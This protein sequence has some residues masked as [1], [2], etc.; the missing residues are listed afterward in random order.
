MMQLSDDQSKAYDVLMQ[1][2]TSNT[3]QCC[4]LEGKPGT[5]KTFLLKQVMK[6]YKKP[7]IFTAPTNKATKVLY[8][9]LS[10]STYQPECMTIFRALG[11]Q[12]R[13]E[14]ELAEL[15]EKEY[16]PDLT[17]ISLLILD[18]AS[19]ANKALVQAIK[20]A[21]GKYPHLKLLVIMD[22]YQ[23]PPINEQIS[24]IITLFQ[25][26]DNPQILLSKVMRHEGN[27]LYVV[28][29]IRDQIDRP[30]KLNFDFLKEFSFGDTSLDVQVM[31][32]SAMLEAAMHYTS[33]YKEFDK[34]K[35]IAWRNKTTDLIN[36]KIRE[37]LFPNT[38]K[39]NFWEIGDKI[40]LTQPAIDFDTDK[41]IAN[42]DDTGTIIDIDYIG[43]PLVSYDSAKLIVSMDDTNSIIKLYLIAPYDKVAWTN[44]LNLQF[45]RAKHHE[46]KWKDY[47]NLHGS[48]HYAKHNYSITAHRAQ[49]STYE[50]VFINM[51]DIL[52]NMNRVEALKCL[53]VATS[54]ASK[55][56]IIGK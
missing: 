56:L 27:I 44:H 33:E 13:K 34:A 40:I 38:H 37:R 51:N 3:N 25:D 17:K 15:E 52:Q 19:M 43:H 28:N 36:S 12:L 39:K 4:L 11:L 21:L 23:L 31:T 24:D 8:S 26:N 42:T 30:F 45:N 7:T 50:T 55:Q 14:T 9:T 48:I 49:G 54:R 6:D 18:E 20:K 22:R 41:V 32:Q 53:Y 46:I 10:D 1:W 47:W 2:L 16:K 29:N 35:S 5:G